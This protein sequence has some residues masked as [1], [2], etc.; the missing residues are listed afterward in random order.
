MTYREAF[1][2]TIEQFELYQKAFQIQ[3]VD[4]LHL[5]ARNAWMSQAAKATKGRGKNIR[6]AYKSFDQFFDWD[7]EI[8]HI[9]QP[10]KRR[11]Q[12]DRMAEINRLM[13][14]YLEKGGI[15]DG[16]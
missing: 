1:N 13:T 3:T 12:V 16:I 6:S 15:D 8:K 2:T 4:N 5:M 14:E 11:R 10:G 9:F 7:G